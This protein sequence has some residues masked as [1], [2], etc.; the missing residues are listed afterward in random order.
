MPLLSETIDAFPTGPFSHDGPE[1]IAEMLFE[2]WNLCLHSQ[3]D[4]LRFVLAP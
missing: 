3:F 4:I 1:A 2:Q